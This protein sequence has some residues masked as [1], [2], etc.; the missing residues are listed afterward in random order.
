MT[1][2]Y[3]IDADKEFINIEKANSL[4]D[5]VVSHIKNKKDDF[6]ES[7]ISYIYLNR[8]MNKKLIIDFSSK[9]RAINDL[10]FFNISHTKKYI[11]IAI[12]SSEVGVDIENSSRQIRKSLFK[13]VL[14]D[15]EIA[16]INNDED[17][18]KCW[19]KKEAYLKMIGKGIFCHL[20]EINSLKIENIIEKN[21]NDY[22][23]AV[24]TSEKEDVKFH[25]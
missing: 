2:V 8:I 17:F 25:F 6:I 22:Y 3:V 12:S 18:L 19:V 16:I 23:L 10:R 9:P 7:L 11:C 24:C 15:E 14:T 1:D 5:S 21:E 4:D 13:K 20:N